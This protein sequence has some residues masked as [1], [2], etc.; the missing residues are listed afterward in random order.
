MRFKRASWEQCRWT[1][2]N[3]PKQRDWRQGGGGADL[4]ERGDGVLVRKQ[5]GSG[6]GECLLSM[7]RIGKG[8][9]REG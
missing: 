3:L 1:G 8:R 9:A 2:W 4:P 6:H 7:P 5:L